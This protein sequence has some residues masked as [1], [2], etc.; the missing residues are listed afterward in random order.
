MN[1]S[2]VID[3]QKLDSPNRKDLANLPDPIANVV[4]KSRVSDVIFPTKKHEG[5]GNT[6]L[7]SFLACRHSDTETNCER[8]D[9]EFPLGD[10]LLDDTLTIFVVD[11]VWQQELLD[12]STLPKG[13]RVQ[14]FSQLEKIDADFVAKQL[15]ASIER[16]AMPFAHDN[17]QSA[18]DG[19]F[20]DVD[21]DVDFESPVH[22]L[23]I[24][25][26]EQG[27]YTTQLVVRLQSSAKA[28]VI[29]HFV[30]MSSGGDD[31]SRASACNA[32]SEYCVEDNAVL[33]HY[34]LNFED[35]ESLHIGSCQYA[36]HRSAQLSSFS[37]ALG[38]DLVRAD[39]GVDF[40]GEGAEALLTGVYLPNENDTVDYHTELRHHAAH[41]T[42]KEVFRGIISDKGRAVFNGRI[43]IK[44]D[45][46]KTLAELSNKNLLASLKAEVFTKPELEIYA[47]DVQCAHG[48]TVA[49][50]DP[51]AMHYLR[52]RGVSESQSRAMLSAG[53][54]TELVDALDNTAVQTLLRPLIASRFSMAAK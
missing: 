7:K 19:L 12:K 44:R 35:A 31:A 47:D 39:I 23:Y 18:Q 53:F 13:V 51:N 16:A 2:T 6:P 32:L 9:Q 10:Y 46:Q 4:R 25:S 36:L 3:I 8:E 33:S 21:K 41:C 50:L 20:I 30:D 17:V 14:A 22:V 24:N 1:A 34:R 15:Q 29:E 48:A 42:S 49:A 43:Y 54:V 26:H 28:G 45:A 5:W 11:G 38:S 37:C 40:L 52:S 27:H